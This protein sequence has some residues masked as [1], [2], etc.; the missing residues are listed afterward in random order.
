MKFL[1]TCDPGLEDIAEKEIKQKDKNARVE[2]FFNFQGKLLVSSK[3]KKLMNLH[4]IH[5]VVRLLKTFYLK[6]STLEEI[7]KVLSK[8]EI[9]Q[10]K[11]AKRFR[12]TSQRF[13]EHNFTSIDMQKI[14]GEVFLEKYKKKVDLENY[15]LNIRF[16]L[17]G[18]FGYV[19]LQLTDDSLYKRYQKPFNHIAAIKSTI[20][21][22]MIVLSDIKKGE[23]ILDPMCGSGTIPMEAASLFKNKVKIIGGDIDERCVQGS[24][25]NARLNNLD[26][27]IEFKKI[28]AVRLEDYISSVDKI[29]TNPPYGVRIEKRNLKEFYKK[30]LLSSA[31]VLDEGKITLITL[32][33][34]MFRHILFNTRKYR[35]IHERVVEAGGIYP[36]IFV[37]Q[38]I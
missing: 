12:V 8:I 13:G 10:M 35:I 2:R 31:K 28:D 11:D 9:P 26:K 1:V 30:F 24:I 33:A 17:V 38:K 14:A 7:K 29:I 5:H 3:G 15:D 6:E 19:G 36:H 22:A 32:K 20:A 23:S 16:D 27:Y 25:E 34:N 37:L 4:S 21:Y 18:K